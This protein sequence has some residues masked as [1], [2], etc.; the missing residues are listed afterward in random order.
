MTAVDAQDAAVTIDASAVAA[1]LLPDEASAAGDH[2]YAQA[3]LRPGAFQAPAL[4]AWEA[5]NL[6]ATAQRRGRITPD[7]ADAALAL[8]T[9]VGVRLEG[10]PDERR[11]QA[12]LDLARLH[13][14]T[15]YDASYLEQALRTSARLAT[16][17]AALRR[18]ATR[19]GVE[20]LDL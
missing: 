11:L 18:Q 16:K 8:L 4:L 20:C 12:T 6:L 15:V 14:L 5:A 13:A 9:K 10:A 3:L 1:W 17:D 7:H 19:A 2:L